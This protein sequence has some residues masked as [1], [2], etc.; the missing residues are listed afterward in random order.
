[1]DYSLPG[2]SIHGIFQA[3]VLEWG[4]IAFSDIVTEIGLNQG[5]SEEPNRSNLPLPAIYLK[6]KKK[7]TL[8]CV[9]STATFHYNSRAEYTTDTVR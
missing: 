8:I 3:R 1:M 7:V 4:A 2:S 6:K 5:F 9:L